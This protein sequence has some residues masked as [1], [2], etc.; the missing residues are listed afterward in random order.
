MATHTITFTE[1]ENG[2]IATY[3]GK[4]YVFSSPSDIGKIF[5]EGLGEKI[6]IHNAGE[7]KIN[8]IKAVRNATG[9]GL[10]ESKDF[11][12]LIQFTPQTFPLL[13]ERLTT[14]LRRDLDELKEYGVV[15]EM[16][17]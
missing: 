7:R 5:K 2:I 4:R 1:V 6:R 15:Y 8:V 3:K 10:R 14:Q 17:S 16:V 13:S 11:T 9:W 12:D